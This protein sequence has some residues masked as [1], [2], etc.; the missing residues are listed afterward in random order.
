MLI[1]EA[2][3]YTYLYRGFRTFGDSFLEAAGKFWPRLNVGKG[4]LQYADFTHL[5]H[6]TPSQQEWPYCINL[7]AWRAELET[8]TEPTVMV[9]PVGL[10]PYAIRWN[11]GTQTT[12][13]EI[14]AVFERVRQR[15]RDKAGLRPPEPVQ[16]PVRSICFYVRGWAPGVPKLDEDY[17]RHNL[18]PDFYR[19]VQEWLRWNR[20]FD[21]DSHITVYT[22]GPESIRDTLPC[23]TLVIT[24]E[25]DTEGLWA[26]LW[27]MVMCDACALGHGQFGSLLSIYRRGLMFSSMDRNSSVPVIQL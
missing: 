27:S 12:R 6:F 3:G 4:E 18:I 17:A 14:S 13:E 21:S 19:K 25:S 26:A 8:R 7:E 23:D 24:P 22:Q 2:Y 10:L 16:G 15:L 9:L 1:A 11:T 20:G 5:P